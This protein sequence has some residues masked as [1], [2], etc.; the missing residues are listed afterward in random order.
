MHV[1]VV[2]ANKGGVGKSTIALQLAAEI[3]QRGQRVLAIDADKQG[4]LTRFAGGC[5]EEHQG[6]DAVLADPPGSLDPRPYLV[7]IRPRID[8]LGASPR[9]ADVEAVI[10]Q[11]LDDGPYYLRRALDVVQ[12][13]YD[14]AVIDMGHSDELAANCV[15]AADVLLMPTTANFPD[16]NHAGD[17]LHIAASLRQE[18]R[19]PKIDLLQ[20]SVISIWRRQHNG[21][22]DAHVI[23]KLRERYGELVS[24]VVLPHS[25]RVSEANERRRTVREY[26]VEYG[27]ARDKSLHALVEAYSALTDFV[28]SKVS[29][30]EAVAV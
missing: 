15:V 27:T 29:V 21:A 8:L 17:M 10:E 9:L 14:W 18:L 23:G 6:L 3:A 28:L 11:G 20:Q 4:D 26:A 7:S 2:T 25:S 5:R 16:A 24:P 13:R 1:V 30:R 19:L 22:A 12:D